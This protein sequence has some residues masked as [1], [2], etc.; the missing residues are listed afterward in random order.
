MTQPKNTIRWFV[1]A[2][3]DEPKLNS[4]QPCPRGVHC[5]YKRWNPAT[6]QM[7]PALCRFVHPGEEGTGRRFFP[8]RQLKE[9]GADIRQQPACVRL[10]G[11]A[12]G[13]YE[14]CGRNIT[15]SAW[16]AQKGIPYEPVTPGAEWEPVTI[17]RINKGGFS[18]STPRRTQKPRTTPPP[19]VHK[20]RTTVE[21]VTP[22]HIQEWTPEDS[23]AY[24]RHCDENQGPD[25]SHCHPESGCDGDHGDEMRDG[26]IIR[27][28]ALP[29]N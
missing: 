6:K 17:E 5:D 20:R 4:P 29:S 23:E 13:F 8:A 15:W 18:F 21:G 16:C 9:V 10:T 1:K 27:K 14:R 19:L 22:L 28:S 25:C 12:R 11:A 3:F 2:S 7:E 26:F 24:Q